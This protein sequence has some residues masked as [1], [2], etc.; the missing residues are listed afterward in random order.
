MHHFVVYPILRMYQNELQALQNWENGFPY[1]G[2]V[3]P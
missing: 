1:K 3:Y 2:A